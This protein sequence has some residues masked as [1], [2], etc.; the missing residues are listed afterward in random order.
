MAERWGTLIYDPEVVGPWIAERSGWTWSPQR[1]TAIGQILNGRLAAGI[2]F[3]DYTGPN[4]VAHIAAERITAGFL[5]ALFNYAFVQ[6]GCRRMTAPVH[7]NN[8]TARQF[9]AKL[10]FQIEATLSDAQPLGDIIIYRLWSKDC[11]WLEGRNGRFPPL[12]A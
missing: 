7:S 2:M 10:G 9:V 3:E 11:R 8:L 12:A 5:R 1:G 4:V 6:L